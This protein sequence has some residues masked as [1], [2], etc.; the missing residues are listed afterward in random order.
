MKWKVTQQFT[1]FQKET[2]LQQSILV[3]EQNKR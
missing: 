1:S 3:L 2:Q